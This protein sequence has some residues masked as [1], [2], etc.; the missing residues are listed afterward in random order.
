ME[1]AARI[2]NYAG[3]VVVMKSG[4]ATANTDEIKGAINSDHL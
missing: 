2:A 3:S 1:E 4:T